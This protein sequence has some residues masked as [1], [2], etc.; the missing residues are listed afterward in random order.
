M[1]HGENL[2][3]MKIK[4]ELAGITKI[5]GEIAVKKNQV[6]HAVKLKNM[7]KKN[8]DVCLTRSN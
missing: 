2:R 5:E 3:S 8:N 7:F 1:E 6:K 4:C